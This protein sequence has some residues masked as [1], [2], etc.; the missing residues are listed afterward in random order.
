ME[1]F[2]IHFSILRKQFCF[3]CSA[4]F[5][6]FRQTGPFSR[7]IFG[8]DLSMSCVSYFVSNIVVLLV[9][10]SLQLSYLSLPGFWDTFQNFWYSQKMSF[11]NL[12]SFAGV[13]FIA[14]LRL[15][16]F[17]VSIRLLATSFVVV[18]FMPV[19]ILLILWSLALFLHKVELIFELRLFLCNFCSSIFRGLSVLHHICRKKFCFAFR[20]AFVLVHLRA[21]R[22]DF[23]YILMSCLWL[24]QWNLGLMFVSVFLALF[25]SGWGL[26]LRTFQFSHLIIL[27]F[28]CIFILQSISFSIQQLKVLTAFFQNV[29]CFKCFVCFLIFYRDV[30]FSIKALVLIL[31]HFF[32]STTTARYESKLHYQ[33]VCLC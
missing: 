26:L 17:F 28:R 16:F 32:H 31:F 18:Y 21:L 15:F 29:F 9:I 3:L 13:S 7:T 4:I 19:Q 27:H 11:L 22:S 20:F 10:V 2:G 8:V 30:P 5:H 33:K 12:I 25:F 23:L 6:L 1:T 14:K 24:F